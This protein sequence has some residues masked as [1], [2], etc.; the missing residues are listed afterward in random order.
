MNFKVSNILLKQNLHNAHFQ[1]NVE[2]CAE[3]LIYFCSN[4]YVAEQVG[5]PYQKSLSLWLI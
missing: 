2:Q 5:L 1:I 3:A 4:S